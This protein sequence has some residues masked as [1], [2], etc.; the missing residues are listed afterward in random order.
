MGCGGSEE[1]TEK[2]I[3][4]EQLTNTT[5]FGNQYVVPKDSTMLLHMRAGGVMDWASQ[6][7]VVDINND[8]VVVL[9]VDPPQ[10]HTH[11]IQHN[12][13]HTTHTQTC[14]LNR[15]C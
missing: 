9:Q 11:T 13:Q 7:N 5:V 4:V 3:V 15:R 10:T 2:P 1:G 14:A 12:S 8:H 6:Y